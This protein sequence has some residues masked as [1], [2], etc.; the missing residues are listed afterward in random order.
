M[1]ILLLLIVLIS[2]S[3]EY[4]PQDPIQ[5]I[6]VLPGEEWTLGVVIVGDTG[7]G[8]EEQYLVAQAI[9]SYCMLEQCDDGL[10][11]GDNIYDK[12]VKD[13]NDKKFQTH[14]EKPYKDIPFQF[15]V[16]L[17]NHD[18]YGNW[19]AQIEYKSDRWLLPDRWYSW[20]KKGVDFFG[21]DSNFSAFGFIGSKPQ[22]EWLDEALGESEARWKIVYG[23]HPVH[24]GGMHGGTPRMRTRLEPLLVEHR[25]DFYAAGHDHDLQLLQSDGI[26]YI[27]SGAGAKLRGTEP[28]DET[29]WQKSTLG[30]AHILFSQN[31]ARLRY[32]DVNSRV[33]FEKTYSK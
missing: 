22:V 12:G 7:T 30:F 3:K 11:L 31:T 18:A 20:S 16:V 19:K 23:H 13:V 24:S 29:V 4:E 2:C 28:I 6:P 5:P 25:V 8:E 9:S 14:F 15:K 26:V 32:V 1:K 27:V 21:I 33:I 10:L 17:G